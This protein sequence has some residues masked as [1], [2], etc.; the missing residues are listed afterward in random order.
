[1]HRLPG[2]SAMPVRCLEIAMRAPVFRLLSS[3][4]QP[5]WSRRWACIALL[6]MLSPLPSHAQVTP[7][8]QAANPDAATVAP[9]YQRLRPQP[10]LTGAT[11]SPHA[12]REGHEAVAAFPRGHADIVA[13]EAQQRAAAPQSTRGLQEAPMAGPAQAHPHHRHPA[14]PD[15]GIHLPVQNDPHSLQGGAR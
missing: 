7:A 5:A 6:A 2:G 15:G 4:P 9:A 1:M 14:P 3:S 12:W 10:L 13:W 11:P 8:D